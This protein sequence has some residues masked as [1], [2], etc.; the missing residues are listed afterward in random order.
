MSKALPYH[1]VDLLNLLMTE[2]AVRVCWKL[3][4]CEV[5]KFQLQL[6]FLHFDS[7]VVNNIKLGLTYA[8]TE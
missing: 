7:V 3:L 8:V 5:I 4:L 6:T 2:E 1:A